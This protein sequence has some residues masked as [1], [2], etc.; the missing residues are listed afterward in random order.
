MIDSGW[1]SMGDQLVRSTPKW[2]K[3]FAW[4]PIQIEGERIWWKT[5]YR[6]LVLQRTVVETKTSIGKG[7]NIQRSKER[8]ETAWEYGTI[9]NVIKND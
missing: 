3:W 5:V 1:N 6:R 8:I 2:E 9:F 4:Y 7:F